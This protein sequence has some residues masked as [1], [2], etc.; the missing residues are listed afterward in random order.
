MNN[1]TTISFSAAWYL[2]AISIPMHAQFRL[3][4]FTDTDPTIAAVQN[5]DGSLVWALDMDDA[6]VL[7]RGDAAGEP[8]WTKEVI[9]PGDHIRLIESEGASTT[10]IEAYDPSVAPLSGS[11]TL[12]TQRLRIS[13]INDQGM[14]IWS[15]EFEFSFAHPIEFSVTGLAIQA[16]RTS[17]DGILATV[18]QTSGGPIVCHLLRVAADGS[19]LWGER[20]GRP[21]GAYL[22]MSEVQIPTSGLL[23]TEYA[24][25]RFAISLDSGSPPWTIEVHA[26][27]AQGAPLTSRSLNY[28]GEII[29]RRVSCVGATANGDLL[30]GGRMSTM[31]SANIMMYRLDADLEYLDGDV[32]WDISS[33]VSAE[34]RTLTQRADGDRLIHVEGALP[35]R[36]TYLIEVDNEGEILNT[37]TS[38]PIPYI[39]DQLLVVHPRDVRFS[40]DGVQL[41]HTLTLTHPGLGDLGHYAERSTVQLDDPACYFSP[42]VVQHSQ[43]PVNIIVTQAL[44]SNVTQE[45]MVLVSAATPLIDHAPIGTVQGCQIASGVSDH[46]QDPMFELLMNVLAPGSALLVR[47]P[48]PLVLSIFDAQG[49]IIRHDLTLTGSGP[50]SVPLPELTAGMYC[51]TAFANR[52]TLRGALRFV[53]E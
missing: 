43:I 2:F 7:W 36:Y 1:S 48:A 52:N 33:T 45:T 35:G 41:A 37:A 44:T 51:V 53:V 23:V 18:A 10:M 4:Q 29:Y 40:E 26:I 32:Y 24:D 39:D 12:V 19:L 15:N 46:A 47:A 31:E 25:G 9:D 6:M 42:G 34:M 14:V 38:V 49:R 17:D 50:W 21:G 11:E 28:S 3:D 16:T 8:M 13:R 5:A 27:D 30:I 22:A 20:I